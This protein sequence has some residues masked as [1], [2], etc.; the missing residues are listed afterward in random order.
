VL[1]ACTFLARGDG[2]LL[3]VPLAVALWRRR[4]CQRLGP[5][6]RLF[7]TAL[8]VVLPWLVYAQLTFGSA[9]P[10]T[11]GAKLAQTGGGTWNGDTFAK[12]IP[13]YFAWLDWRD[14]GVGPWPFAA[15]LVTGAALA[16]RAGSALHGIRLALAWCGLQVAAY[17]AL[18]V[19]RYHWYFT[20]M[21]FATTLAA[22]SVVLWLWHRRSLQPIAVGFCC[23]WLGITTMDYQRLP[24]VHYPTYE[25]VAQWIVA[26]TPP[27][28]TVAMMDIGVVGWRIGDRP[29]VDMCS[30]VHR[31]GVAEIAA[32]RSAW[33]LARRP[34][35]VICHVPPRAAYEKVAME[36][37]EFDR[38]YQRVARPGGGIQVFGRRV[39]RR[40]AR[41]T[42]R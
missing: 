20:Q 23:A 5:A 40:T 11:L 4:E 31:E 35:F 30:L 36:R 18:G 14:L 41:P 15:V 6:A 38:D 26:N 32:G 16:V 34:D 12:W 21:L 17:V 24:A 3:G 22:G 13:Y 37:P 39:A 25:K 19:P 2:L 28:A 33:W 9:V 27:D 7:G 10:H 29:V 8:L 1:F 42:P